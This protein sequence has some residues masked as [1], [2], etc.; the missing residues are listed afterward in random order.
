M[1]RRILLGRYAIDA[2]SGSPD[3]T[4][5]LD[6]DDV[7]RASIVTAFSRYDANFYMLFT[8]DAYDAECDIRDTIIS[9][10]RSLAPKIQL[11]VLKVWTT[12]IPSR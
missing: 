12:P 11:D 7:N 2:E 5:E 9:W 6:A 4:V 10:D 3:G 1:M 8:G